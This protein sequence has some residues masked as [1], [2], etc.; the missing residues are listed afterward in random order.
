MSFHPENDLT[1]PRYMCMGVRNKRKF[2]DRI[3]AKS[4]S[5]L[6]AQI[7]GEYL[8]LVTVTADG[9]LATIAALR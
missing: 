7:K 8:T 4:S 2:L 9:C 6:V 5:K 3:L 1:K